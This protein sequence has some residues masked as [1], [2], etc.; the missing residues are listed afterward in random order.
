MPRVEVLTDKGMLLGTALSFMMAVTALSLPE[1]MILK[2]I[3]HVRL[4]ALFFS[5]VGFA[6][7]CI[8]YIFNFIL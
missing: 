1:A 8:G 6:I 3:L 2:R 7:I 4:I 5:I